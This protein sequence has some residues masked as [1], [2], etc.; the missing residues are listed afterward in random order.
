MKK[1][2]SLFLSLIVYS[3]YTFAACD[4]PVSYITKGS[5]AE[6]SGY[7]FSP[8]LEQEVRGMAQNYE[9][10]K[11]IVLQQDELIQ[12]L[13]KR[14]ALQMSV[15]QNLR[16]QNDYLTK[17]TVIQKAIWFGVGV[18]TTGLIVYASRR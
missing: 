15:N 10:L 8:E 4:K 3:Q 14:V 16:D 1:A 7:L 9:K 6:C 13:D 11:V 2:L 17:E 12:V 18:L 5:R